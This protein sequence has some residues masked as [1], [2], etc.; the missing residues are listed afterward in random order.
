[1]SD[2]I[3]VVHPTPELFDALARAQ[4][5]ARTVKKGGFNT[6][7]NYN[8]ATAEDMLAAGRAARKGTGLALI[9]SWSVQSREAGPPLLTLAWLLTHSSGGM[10]RGSLVAPIQQSKRNGPDKQ[11]AALATYLEG[12][13][14]RGLMRLDRE[15]TPPAED[16]DAHD[17]TADVAA[18]ARD[19]AV[20]LDERRRAAKLDREAKDAAADIRSAHQREVEK[21]RRAFER[22]VKAGRMDGERT[23]SAVVH[24]AALGVDEATVRGWLPKRSDDIDDGPDAVFPDEATPAD[25]ERMAAEDAAMARATGAS[26]RLERDTRAEVAGKP[27]DLGALLVLTDCATG[28]ELLSA[29]ARHRV[30]LHELDPRILAVALDEHAQRLDVDTKA[31]DAAMVAE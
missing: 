3:Q 30:A 23:A 11:T 28:K 29:L 24:F 26:D 19:H 18:A 25:V 21:A 5:Q 2:E 12:F 4:E 10:L 9:T 15:G 20:A 8:Y 6:H 7:A 27:Q 31:I 1:M 14:E 16:R 22:E 17:D 13:V